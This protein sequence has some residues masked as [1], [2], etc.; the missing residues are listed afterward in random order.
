MDC[1]NCLRKDPLHHCLLQE[2]INFYSFS[3]YIVF[4]AFY[5]V[6]VILILNAFI[7]HYTLSS[8]S[9]LLLLFAFL[10]DHALLMSKF[11]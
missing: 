2:L 8:S 7:L 5:K 11:K 6:M 4:L 9:L 1:C 3:I 10:I